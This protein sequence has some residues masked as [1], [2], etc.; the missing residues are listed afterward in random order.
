MEMALTGSAVKGLGQYY[1]AKDAYDSW[2]LQCEEADVLPFQVFEVDIPPL[3]IILAALVHK[4]KAKNV[5]HGS[6]RIRIFRENMSL[7]EAKTWNAGHVRRFELFINAPQFTT[8]IKYYCQVPLF[9]TGTK[10]N[11]PQCAATMDIYGDHLLQC[12]RGTHRIRRH[13]AQI[14][15]LQAGLKKTARHPV[16]EPQPFGRQKERPD[17][18]AL[19]S[20]GDSDMFDITIC[21]PLSQA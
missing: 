11:R 5:S 13:D 3:Q 1:F 15:L 17:I 6:T 19:G 4:R 8:W 10:C 2:T 12:E 20:H 21:H 18:S 9:Q 14:R 7:P 16:L